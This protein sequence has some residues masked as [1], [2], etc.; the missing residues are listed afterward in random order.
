[1][2]LFNIKVSL[3][4]GSKVMAFLDIS[5][6]KIFITKKLI[7]DINLAIKQGFMLE[8]VSYIN[9]NCFCI[10]VKVIIQRLKTRHLIFIVNTND[11]NFISGHLVLNYGKLC[12]KYKPDKI[13]NTI[14]HLY[15]DQT[16]VFHTLTSQRPTN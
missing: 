6:E 5:I 14:M 13:F 7:K 15:M 16:S 12:Q 4:N 3:E 11:H 1:M 8:L 10:D 9:H 2:G